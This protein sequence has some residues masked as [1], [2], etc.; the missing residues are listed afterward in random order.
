M[1][2]EEEEEEVGYLNYKNFDGRKFSSSRSSLTS[3]HENVNEVEEC[4]HLDG[5]DGS[6]WA[7]SGKRYPVWPAIVIDPL[8]KAPDSVLKSCIAGAICV[9]Y[10]GYSGDGKERDYAWVKHGMIFSFRRLC[11]QGQT[12]LHKSKPSEFRMAIEKPFSR[13]WLCRYVNG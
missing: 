11:G 9:M 7:R 5:L 12:Q 8:T 6:L 1:E 13:T 4:I 2:E 10:F 3:L